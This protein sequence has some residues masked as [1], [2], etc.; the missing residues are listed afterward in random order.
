MIKIKGRN[1]YISK[2]LVKRVYKRNGKFFL[3]DVYGNTFEIEELDY[4]NLGGK[5]NE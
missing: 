3:V 2:T 4:Y 5:D 1:H